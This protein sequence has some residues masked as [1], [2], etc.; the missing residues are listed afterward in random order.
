MASS[1]VELVTVPKHGVSR[2]SHQL[3]NFRGRNRLL[4]SRAALCGNGPS[5]AAVKDLGK[6]IHRWAAGGGGG[7]CP[8]C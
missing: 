4:T 7:V 6:H 2:A 8:G 3:G 5:N 1:G